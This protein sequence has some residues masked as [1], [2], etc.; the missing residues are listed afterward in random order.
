M[1]NFVRDNK[2]L[3]AVKIVAALFQI[4]ATWNVFVKNFKAAGRPDLEAY[5]T[6]FFAILLIDIFFLAVLYL[7]ESDEL[8]P[9]KKIPWALVGVGLLIATL[10]IGFADEGLFAWMPRVGFIGLVSAD[11]FTWAADFIALM[12]DRDRIEKRVRDRQVVARRRIM[13]K[14]WKEAQKALYEDL[15]YLQYE[16]ERRS[17]GIAPKGNTVSSDPEYQIVEDG[18]IFLPAT[19]SYGWEAEDGQFYCRTVG[20]KNYTLRGAKLARARRL[21]NGP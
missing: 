7:L 6:T 17:L 20:G 19:N 1:Q 12:F 3:W 21:K 4:P 5:I 18:I 15:V 9:I 10:L 8:D 16:R 14:A 13:Q 2:W 11:L